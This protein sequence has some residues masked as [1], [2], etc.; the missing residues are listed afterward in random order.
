M[1]V[2]NALSALARRETLDEATLT[3]ALNEIAGGEVLPEKTGGLLMGIAARGAAVEEL[4]AVV[5]FLRSRMVTIQPRVETPL[6]DTCGTG[7]DGLG[8]FN[9]STTAAILAAAAGAKIAKH[10]NRAASSKSGS[11]DVLE[12]LGVDTAAPAER[13]RKSVETIGIGFLFAPAHHPVMKAVGPVRRSLGVKTIF[14]LAGPL[15]NPAGA[16]RQLVGVYAPELMHLFAQAL[17]EL[18]CQRAMIVHGRDGLDEITLT[19][20]TDF[21]SLEPDGEIRGGVLDPK[22]LGLPYCKP[23]DLAGG[24]PKAN[25]EIT[26]RILSGTETGPAATCVLVNAAAALWVGGVSRDIK[27]GMALAAGAISSGAAGRTLEKLAE[28]SRG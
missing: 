5:R 20:P 25:A 1:T 7:G 17:R 2:A 3:A 13:V 27:Q 11:A 28:I 9:I 16:R 4:V 19:T 22:A 10:G 14:N 8:T 18:G 26:R 12:A 15:S 23:E 24:D 21:V 6:I